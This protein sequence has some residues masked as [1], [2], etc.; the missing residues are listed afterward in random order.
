MR[1][2][3]LI[4]Y[5]ICDPKRLRQ[6]YLTLRGYGDHLQLSVFRCELTERE[7]VELR[8][9]LSELLHMEQDQVLFVD[10]GPAEGRAR[11]CIAALGVAYVAPERLAVVV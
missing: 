3:Y 5:D 6:V 9:K 8:A 1:Q 10:L 4:T 11:T 7:H 2:A